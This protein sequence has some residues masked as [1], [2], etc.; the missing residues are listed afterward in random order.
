LTKYSILLALFIGLA[1]ASAYGCDEPSGSML[2]SIS[3]FKQKLR[4]QEPMRVRV[5]YMRYDFRPPILIT[6]PMME[7]D[8]EIQVDQS[9]YLEYANSLEKLFERAPS[10]KGVWLGAFHWGIVFY[11]ESGE[12]IFSAYASRRYFNSAAGEKVAD[13][14]VGMN[15]SLSGWFEENFLKQGQD[16]SY[17]HPRTFH[18]R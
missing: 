5:F 11:S 16:L 10:C 9:K 8:W 6:I 13:V 3:A 14:T 2:Q 17:V 1:N 7:R 4:A 15:G 12:R 18:H